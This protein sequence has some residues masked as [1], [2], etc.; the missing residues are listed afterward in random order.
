MS[1]AASASMGSGAI[2]PRIFFSA[3]SASLRRMRE[4]PRAMGITTATTSAATSSHTSHCASVPMKGG[5]VSQ[6]N[7]QGGEGGGRGA[8]ALAHAAT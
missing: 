7:H 1:D 2:V 6:R 3:G 5:M 4:S 8:V